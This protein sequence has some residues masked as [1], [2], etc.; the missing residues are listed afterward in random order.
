MVQIVVKDN[1]DQVSILQCVQ[2]EV[3]H[4]HRH[5]EPQIR[6]RKRDKDEHLNRVWDVFR[7]V[8][9]CNRHKVPTSVA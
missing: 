3:D 5:L 4:F 2:E 8:F 1:N 9:I 6:P 7:M